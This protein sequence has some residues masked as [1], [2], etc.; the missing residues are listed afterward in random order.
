VLKADASAQP[1]GIERPESQVVTDSEI[2]D[3]E[4][5]FPMPEDPPEQETTSSSQHFGN[6]EEA[7]AR[8][9]RQLRYWS[10]KIEW[11]SRP[12]PTWW[13]QAWEEM[14]ELKRPDGTRI[15]TGSPAEFKECI[16]GDVTATDSF[17]FEAMVDGS[18]GQ[19]VGP[20]VNLDL[21][22]VVAAGV[23]TESGSTII[24]RCGRDVDINEL[25]LAAF[26]DILSVTPDAC[27]LIYIT[28]SDWLLGQWSDMIAWKDADY[29]GLDRK[30]C[31][32]YWEDIMGHAET[33]L[34]KVTM[35][36]IN[37]RE[38]WPPFK[39]AVRKYGMEGIEWYRRFMETPDG[40][41][42]PPAAPLF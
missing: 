23:W 5:P 33:R 16:T 3:D 42:Y 38:V 15:P 24:R 35:Y 18:P 14:A 22:N 17:A 10:A 21:T 4:C 19:I 37:D 11:E 41:E 29:Q 40:G 34:S 13:S 30:A 26:K 12:K 25:S 31:P 7:M 2:T 6:L 39:E 9:T 28:H 8:A 36:H 1:F 32:H 20:S 27:E